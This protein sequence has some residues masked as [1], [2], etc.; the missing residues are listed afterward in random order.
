[1]LQDGLAD[2]ALVVEAVVTDAT[3][4]TT[5]AFPIA[6]EAFAGPTTASWTG[7]PAG[8]YRLRHRAGGLDRIVD[9]VTLGSGASGGG[10]YVLA[11]PPTPTPNLGSGEGDVA[12]AFFVE[13]VAPAVQY[14]STIDVVL[15]D[16]RTGRVVA[17]GEAAPDG[18]W[19]CAD[20]PAG[21]WTL[22]AGGSLPD[23]T[24]VQL[25][26]GPLGVAVETG[27]TLTIPPLALHP[28]IG[29]LVTAY[30]VDPDAD[31]PLVAEIG[32]MKVRLYAGSQLI[33]E[34]TTGDFHVAIGGV[35]PGV[36]RLEV[37]VTGHATRSIPLDLT[38]VDP[39][40][41]FDH[42]LVAMELN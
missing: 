14:G 2:G 38:A 11:R 37:Q 16:A 10:T 5:L 19:S 27:T 32:E 15:F 4:G 8:T 42:Y 31:D 40:T 30:S 6:T 36:D 22:T 12:G 23:G 41:H 35:S 25:L 24:A 39:T 26:H 3:T 29:L 34:R 20:V 28:A 21:D 33:T 7:L 1:M 13:G 9:E 17:E 18:S